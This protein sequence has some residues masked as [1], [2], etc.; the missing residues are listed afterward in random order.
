[1]AGSP[2]LTHL[3]W[4]SPGRKS[5]RFSTSVPL[6]S[7][8]VCSRSVTRRP[9]SSWAGG[10]SMVTSPRSWLLFYHVTPLTTIPCVL[11]FTD[12]RWL[13]EG[14]Y[15][16][17]CGD[18]MNVL[19]KKKNLFK[20]NTYFFIFIFFY[21]FLQLEDLVKVE[22]MTE[23]RFSSFMKVSWLLNFTFILGGGLADGWPCVLV[24]CSNTLV[25]TKRSQK[26]DWYQNLH[27]MNSNIFSDGSTF[28]LAPL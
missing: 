4:S 20:F 15:W 26:L 22:G 21:F 5:C 16:F 24:N 8:K 6:K 2:S 12:F 1:M 28:H 10:R 19:I 18:F 7:W 9:S 3:C 14:R 27:R 17:T 23:K 13:I 25:R 11:P